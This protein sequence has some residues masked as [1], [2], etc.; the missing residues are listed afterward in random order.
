MSRVSPRSF[1]SAVEPGTNGLSLF[2]DVNSIG[3]GRSGRPSTWGC[4]RTCVS[5]TTGSVFVMVHRN[6]VRIA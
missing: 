5:I 6:L 4:L 3:Q 2:L 1:C